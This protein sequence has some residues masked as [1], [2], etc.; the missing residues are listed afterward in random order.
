MLLGEEDV[1]SIW[2]ITN[3]QGPFSFWGEFIWV[4][5]LVLLWAKFPSREFCRD[6]CQSFITLF[7][8]MLGNISA[9][10]PSNIKSEIQITSLRQ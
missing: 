4:F 8:K 1:K 6:N 2:N 5:S 10:Y 3:L 9:I 7:L